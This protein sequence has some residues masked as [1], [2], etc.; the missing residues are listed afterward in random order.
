M[1][2]FIHSCLIHLLIHLFTSIRLFAFLPPSNPMNDWLVVSP[3]L[4]NMSSSI[5]MMTFP[6]Q[7]KII[8]MFQTTKQIR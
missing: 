5:G 8:Q 2:V 1:Y 4:K 6:T 3:L 7:G